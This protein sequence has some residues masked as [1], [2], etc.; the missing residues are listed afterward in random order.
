M[1]RTSS[2]K[3]S[4]CTKAVQRVVATSTRAMLTCIAT[5]TAFVLGPSGEFF[6]PDNFLSSDR[7]VPEKWAKS[8]ST[9]VARLIDFILHMVRMETKGCDCLC[10]SLGGGTGSAMGTRLISKVREE[11]SDRITETFTIILSPK[12]SDTAVEP[13]NTMPSFH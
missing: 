4:T 8:H 11:Q 9:E 3:E 5:C 7:R 12:A 1:T 2:W 10:H 6:K 13:Y